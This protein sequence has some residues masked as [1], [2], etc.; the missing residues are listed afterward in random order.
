MTTMVAGSIH[1][2]G[3]QMA[4]SPGG[5]VLK[6]GDYVIGAVEVSGAAG[7]EDEYCAIRAVKEA[8]IGLET[9]PEVHSCSQRAVLSRTFSFLA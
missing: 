3:N 4:P 5:I 1:V 8:N 6:L 2:S 7:D 9:L